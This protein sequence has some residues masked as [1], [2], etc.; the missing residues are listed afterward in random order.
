MLQDFAKDLITEKGLDS[1]DP[2]VYEMLVNQIS[3][4]ANEMINARIVDSMTDETLE[5]FNKLIDTNPDQA[6]VH[7]FI[8]KNVPN[9]HTIASSALMEFKG[10]YLGL[11]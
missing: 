7:E 3:T 4:K 1:V 11:M 8:D 5:E 2:R 10:L 6:A 9:K